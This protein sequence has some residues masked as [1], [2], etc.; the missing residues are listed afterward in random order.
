M[1][2]NQRENSG[3][4]LYD[5]SKGFVLAGVVGYFADKLPGF[6]FLVHLLIALYF[7][8]RVQFR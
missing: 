8:N 2:T 7:F 4:Y 6:V 3:K 5:L 1:T